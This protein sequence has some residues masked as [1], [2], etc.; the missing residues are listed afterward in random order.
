MPNGYWC[1]ARFSKSVGWT[2]VVAPKFI[3]GGLFC[4]AIG[5]VHLVAADFNPL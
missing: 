4:R 5:S 3:S 1:Y 2:N